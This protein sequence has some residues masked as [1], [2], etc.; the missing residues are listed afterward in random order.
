MGSGKT[1]IGNILSILTNYLF[2]DLDNIIYKVYD[3]QIKKIFNKYGEYNFRII[4]NKI[5]KLFLINKNYNSY[6]LSV[7]GGTPCFLNNIILMNNYS[8]TIYLQTKKYLLY[9]RLLKDNYDRPI[10]NNNIN[11]NNLYN[12]INNNINKRNNYYMK[13]KYVINT[14]KMKFFK[15]AYYIK[16]LFKI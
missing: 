11:N 4:E 14:N 7:G 6:I 15:I 9:Y 3:I 2:Y 12:F 1:Y 10:I 16:N 13:S 8:N 5:L